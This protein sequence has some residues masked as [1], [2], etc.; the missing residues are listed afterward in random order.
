MKLGEALIGRIKLHLT[1]GGRESRT[2]YWLQVFVSTSIVF[3]LLIILLITDI[4]T[5]IFSVSFIRPIFYLVFF[6]VLPSYFLLRFSALT[7]RRLHDI[8][9]SAFGIFI[10]LIPLGI[11]YL[12]YLL[13]KKSD[14]V[15]NRFGPP[16]LS[17]HF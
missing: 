11:F 5:E 17:K 13:L 1:F 6:F 12:F 15:R 14:S 4:Q 10:G 7:S 3:L 9:M 8:D 2:N 16:N